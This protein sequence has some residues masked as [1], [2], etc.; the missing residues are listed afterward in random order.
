[1]GAQSWGQS[2]PPAQADYLHPTERH[3]YVIGWEGMGLTDPVCLQ[4]KHEAG[5]ER[6]EK[7][8]NE[9]SL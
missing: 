7:G 3:R 6:K 5:R 8:E 2:P 1:M 4:I 9:N